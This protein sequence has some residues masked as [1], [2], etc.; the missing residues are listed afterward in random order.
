MHLI[1]QAPSPKTNGCGACTPSQQC[2]A[3]SIEEGNQNV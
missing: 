2:R 3:I 1:E